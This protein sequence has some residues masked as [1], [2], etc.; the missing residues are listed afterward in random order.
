MSLY[1]SLSLSLSL[2]LL[3]Q[4]RILKTY[5]Y[6]DF[7]YRTSY[8]SYLMLRKLIVQIT[9]MPYCSNGIC[10]GIILEHFNNM[11]EQIDRKVKKSKLNN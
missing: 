2:S 8:Q 4:N 9:I 6:R 10:S 1:L 5:I 3:L 7:I 11:R